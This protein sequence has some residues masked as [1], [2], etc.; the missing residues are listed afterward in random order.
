MSRGAVPLSAQRFPAEGYR[1]GARI[2]TRVLYRK[3]ILTQ[4]SACF[5]LQGRMTLDARF[6]VHLLGDVAGA[7]NEPFLGRKKIVTIFLRQRENTEAVIL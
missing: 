4:V 6:G 7:K 1:V 2:V 3:P 5:A